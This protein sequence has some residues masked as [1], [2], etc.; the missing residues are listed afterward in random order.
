MKGG[1][2]H[3]QGTGRRG[4]LAVQ[5][6]D[7]MRARLRAHANLVA[8]S[9]GAIERAAEL[10]RIMVSFSGGKDSTVLLDLVRRVQPEAAAA[11]FNSG[12]EWP[13]TLEFVSRVPAVETALPKMTMREMF[14]SGGY[15]GA[16][17]T[18]KPR[19]KFDWHETLILEPSRRA[20]SMLGA[21]VTAIGLRADESAGRKFS[22][23]RHG[24]LA[25]LRGTWRLCP[26]L[27]WT[28]ADI[29]AYI[30]SRDLDYN[31]L[32]D[33]MTEAGIP[34][35]RQRVSTL[36]E[37]HCISEGRLWEIRR[38]A[39]SLYNELAAEFPKIRCYQ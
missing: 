10:G 24:P 1:D 12:L 23:K 5:P 33:R 15:W 35:E 30:A 8:R 22:A 6:M 26:L 32:Y 21:N 2:P 29:W 16:E 34:R 9:I 19:E 3:E 13:W 17:P 11:F 37:N 27:D 7:R 14:H 18:G 39:P 38:L 31:E 20:A 36:I 4:R 25:E 28:V